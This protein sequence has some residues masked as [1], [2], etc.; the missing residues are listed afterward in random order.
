M[1]LMQF[2]AFQAISYIFFGSYS[3]SVSPS[4]YALI[5]SDYTDV[6]TLVGSP[7][8]SKGSGRECFFGVLEDSPAAFD[9]TLAVSSNIDSPGRYIIQVLSSL[10][11]PQYIWGLEA[12]TQFNN[13]YSSLTFLYFGGISSCGKNCISCMTRLDFGVSEIKHMYMCILH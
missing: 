10:S 9:I 3:S 6:C 12:K 4:I 13:C 11:S 1:I 5:L 8:G 7:T 2:C